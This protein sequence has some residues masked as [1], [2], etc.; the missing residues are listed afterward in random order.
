M[1]SAST[2]A[3]ELD[4]LFSTTELIITSFVP[5]KPLVE[6]NHASPFFTNRC[7]F[8]S[9]YALEN[10]PLSNLFKKFLT[11]SLGLFLVFGFVTVGSMFCSV[12]IVSVV[13][14]SDVLTSRSSCFSSIF[15][16]EI[17]F[18]SSFFSLEK[19]KS[20]LLTFFGNSLNLTKI[21]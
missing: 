12:L 19:R 9:L 20:L 1:Y 6:I 15:E 3:V 21:F 11:S 18:G 2:I 4:L 7:T 17:R 10:S 5:P 14:I 8:W 16:K 13:I